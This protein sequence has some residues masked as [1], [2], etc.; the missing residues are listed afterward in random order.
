[1]GGKTSAA[2]KFKT[3]DDVANRS[4]RNIQSLR[5]ELELFHGSPLDALSEC[6]RGFLIAKPG[7]RFI[8]ADWSAIESR[9]LN[10]LAGEEKILDIYRTHGKIYEYNASGIYSIPISEVDDQKRQIGKVAELALGFCGGVGAFQTMAVNYGVH[11]PDAQAEIIKRGWRENHPNVVRFWE[12][13]ETAAMSA[14]RDPGKKFKVGPITYMKQGS[15]LFCRLPSGRVISYPYPKIEWIQV[16]LKGK[17]PFDIECITSMSVDS[18]SRKW[19]RQ[20]TWKGTL[21][22]NIVQGSSRC[23]LASAIQ[24]LEL[25]GY[26]VVIHNHDE[27][28]CE[29]RD[30][31]GS[32]KEMEAVMCEELP[33]TKGLPL[34]AKGWSGKRYRKG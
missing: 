24:R 2:P 13:V 30:D 5:D 4:R 1:M 10:W 29:V 25:K 20:K 18:V 7:Y 12:R 6:M 11:V 17:E 23:L 26:A 27:I 19:S 22:E 16:K 32:V 8:A 33:W 3:A 21:V 31:F 14:V 9:K 28:V 34:Q 15:F